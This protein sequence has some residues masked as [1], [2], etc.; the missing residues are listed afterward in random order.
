MTSSTQNAIGLVQ[1]PGSNCDADCIEAFKRLFQ[2]DL[3]LIWHEEHEIPAHIQGLILPG[4][5]SY[6]DYLRSGALAAFSPIMQSVKKFAERGGAVLGICNGFQVLCE[7]KLLPG[8]LLKNVQRKFVCEMTSLSVTSEGKSPWHKALAGKSYRVPIAHG[9]GNY[10]ID[11][12][13]LKKL[14]SQGQILFQYSDDKG[15]ASATSNPNGTL[16]NIAGIV[17]ENGRVMGMMPHPERAS[18]ELL[19]SD[20]GAAILKVFMDTALKA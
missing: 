1:F 9:E 15:Q 19:G 20:D 3:H 2:I 8:T 13:G 5:F 11:Q 7:A 17:S 18:S 4:G 12:A 6:G 14:Q 10:Y 16:L